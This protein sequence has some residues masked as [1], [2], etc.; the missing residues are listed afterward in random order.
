MALWIIALIGAY[1]VGSINF[2]ILLFKIIRKNDPRA[3]HSGNPGVTNVYRQAGIVAAFFV[4]ALDV[5][6]AV[7]VAY[8]GTRLFSLEIVDWLGFALIL[9]NRYPCFHGFQGGK[10]VSNLL[11]FTLGLAPAWAGIAAVTWLAVRALVTPSFIPSLAMM[12]GLDQRRLVWTARM[13]I[14]VTAPW[15]ARLC[16]RKNR[17]RFG[18][19]S[20]HCRTG[21][22]G[23]TSSTRCAAVLFH[24]AV[25]SEQES[26]QS[27][28]LSVSSL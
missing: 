27:R 26:C 16:C 20:T 12:A 17:I 24:Q 22:R 25:L 7:L 5:S 3:G 11:G 23:I 2:S 21:T 10:G 14:R 8:L 19:A 9:G 18:T 4:L 1:L 6:R 15:I 28:P 13:K